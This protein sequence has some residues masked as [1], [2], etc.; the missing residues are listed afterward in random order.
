MKVF[1]IF[2]L[3]GSVFAIKNN[4]DNLYELMC[5]NNREFSKDL[6]ISEDALHYELAKFSR[7]FD[8]KHYNNAIQILDKLHEKGVN[9]RAA[10]TTKELYDKSFSFPKVRNYDFAREQLDILQHFE[11]NLN[12]NLKN[13]LALANFISN[14][15][16]V[17]SA[18]ND[19]YGN[20]FID[21]AF[22]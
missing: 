19:R 14:A 12:I 15:K 4:Q 16:K 9:A 22:E 8:I 1:N 20:A 2:L 11:D 17:R 13:E 5:M 7:N 3:C 21:P 18:L 6:E 10:V